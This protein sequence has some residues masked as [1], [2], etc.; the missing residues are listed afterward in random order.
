MKAYHVLY[1]H[2]ERDI[3]GSGLGMSDFRVLEAL[4]HKGPLPVNTIGAQVWLT[5][6]SATAAIDRLEKKRLVRRADDPSDRRARIVHLTLAGRA[7]IERTFAQHREAMESA[8]K[9]LDRGE[10][11]EL[12]ALLKKLG[13]AADGTA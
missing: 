13:K 10:R 5:S 6:G 7:W 9:G 4:L 8:A 2:A 1:R 11:E 3:A 12:V